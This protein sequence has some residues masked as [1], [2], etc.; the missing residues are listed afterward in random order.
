MNDV[1]IGPDQKVRVDQPKETQPVTTLPVKA[2][3]PRTLVTV[4]GILSKIP[5]SDTAKGL[6]FKL[7][8]F[9][10]GIFCG[11]GIV[12]KSGLQPPVAPPVANV[13]TYQNRID[14]LQQENSNLR[15]Q[16]GSAP[17]PVVAQPV[18]QPVS[19]VVLEP[20]VD[21]PRPGFIIK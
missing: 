7:F 13:S 12:Y 10:F 21:A 4:L 20:A 1:T 5:L 15:K 11:I 14:E 16:L 8:I 18:T 3:D 9:V 17:V 19:P 2:I 6:L